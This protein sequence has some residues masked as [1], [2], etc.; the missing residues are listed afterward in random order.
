SHGRSTWRTIRARERGRRDEDGVGQVEE[1][2]GGGR[3]RVNIETREWRPLGVGG[4]LGLGLKTEV[5]VRRDRA[6]QRTR[7]VITRLRRDE[8]ESP[9]RRCRPMKDGRRWTRLPL[10]GLNG[11]KQT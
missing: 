11:S 5:R 9:S 4:F 8:A 6:A 2:L 10:R 3:T 1:G 7:G